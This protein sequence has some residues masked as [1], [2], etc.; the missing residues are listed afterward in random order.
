MEFFDE[1]VLEDRIGVDA[2]CVELVSSPSCVW[3]VEY[4]DGL[5]LPLLGYDTQ[6]LGDRTT[7]CRICISVIGIGAVNQFRDRHAVP[8]D[9]A[10]QMQDLGL[11]RM[12]SRI[13]GDLVVDD[14]VA[15]VLFVCFAQGIAVNAVGSEIV[16]ELVTNLDLVSFAEEDPL[17]SGRNG[18]Y[19][20]AQR[21][22]FR[23]HVVNANG[24]GVQ[25][26]GV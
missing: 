14:A 24:I 9:R 25:S 12:F 23:D 7:R 13:L 6:L 10:V 22:E 15:Q 5:V 26:G 2:G 8:N 4:A 3:S 21:V 18:I 1:A 20:Q 11:N 19:G 17:V 16:V